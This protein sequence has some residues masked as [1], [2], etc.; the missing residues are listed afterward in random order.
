MASAPKGAAEAENDTVS[1]S[2]RRGPG[3]AALQRCAIFQVLNSSPHV[4]SERLL[5]PRHKVL[6]SVYVLEGSHKTGKVFLNVLCLGHGHVL[7]GKSPH[8]CEHIVVEDGAWL[9]IAPFATA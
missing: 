7:A 1:V 8:D 6:H 2:C 4:R 3:E 5:A 9:G